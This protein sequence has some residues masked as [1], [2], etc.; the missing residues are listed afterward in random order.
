MIIA[1]GHTLESTFR[2]GFAG[3]MA[4]LF[5]QACRVCDRLAQ[6]WLDYS[7]SKHAPETW[8]QA[9]SVGVAVP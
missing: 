8:W 9:Q 3:R 1:N 2:A 6:L 5:D 4:D 7:Q